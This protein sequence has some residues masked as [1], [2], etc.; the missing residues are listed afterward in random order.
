MISYL[1]QFYCIFILVCKGVKSAH[2]IM[3]AL[4]VV[5]IQ[6]NFGGCA[7]PKKDRLQSIHTQFMM[8]SMLRNYSSLVKSPGTD[9]GAAAAP[10]TNLQSTIILSFWHNLTVSFLIMITCIY[11]MSCVEGNLFVDYISKYI[12]IWANHYLFHG[13]LTSS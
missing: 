9:D 6:H 11:H 1:L 7:I 4:I 13:R 3:P 8:Q 2:I 12:I 5:R 10:P